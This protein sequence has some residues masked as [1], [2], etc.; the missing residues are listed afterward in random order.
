MTITFAELFDRIIEAFLFVVFI[1]IACRIGTMAV[2]KS[3]VEGL[4]NF[5][6]PCM[7]C[8]DKEA[9]YGQE[10]KGEKEKFEE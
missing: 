5:K 1:Y 2:M 4:I 9:C 10:E 7:F 6:I 3:V 8:R